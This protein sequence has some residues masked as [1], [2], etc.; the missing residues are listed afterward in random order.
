MSIT[1][2]FPFQ[3][4]F[5]VADDTCE[6]IQP[7]FKTYK[8]LAEATN[9]QFF[10]IKS[11]DT[12]AVV[13]DLSADLDDGASILDVIKA[14]PGNNSYPVLV[15]DTLKDFKV[16]LSGGSPSIVVTNPN[17]EVSKKAHEVLDLDNVKTVHVKNPEPG[18]WKIDT[19]S[20]TTH[21]V[22]VSGNSKVTFNFGFSL[23]SP[24]SLAETQKRP[25]HDYSN[26]LCLEPSNPLLL[27]SLDEVRFFSPTF[28]LR[29]PLQPVKSSSVFI[30]AFEPPR[31]IFKIEVF[32]RDASGNPF[33][34]LLPTGVNPI[35]VKKPEY[36][37][38]GL[39][40]FVKVDAGETVDLDCIMAGDPQPTI[41]WFKNGE[42]LPDTMETLLVEEAEK[43]EY[44]C[45]GENNGGS[46]NVTFHVNSANPPEVIDWLLK[47]KN[48]SSVMFDEE[49][50]NFL[51]CPVKGEPE[52]TIAWFRD[53]QP[54]VNSSLIVISE[55]SQNVRFHDI[56]KD[57]TGKYKCVAT[58]SQGSVSLHF[59]VELNDPPKFKNPEEEKKNFIEETEIY[60]QKVTPEKDKEV[61]LKCDVTGNPEPAIYW[62]KEI[63]PIEEVRELVQTNGTEL[64]LPSVE[65]NSVFLCI[66]NNTNGQLEKS[67]EIDVPSL[68]TLKQPTDQRVRVGANEVF[69]MNCDV[70][71]PTGVEIKWLK[72]GIEIPEGLRYKLFLD[73]LVLKIVN[74]TATEMGSY[75][76]VVSNSVGSVEKIFN[77]EM[78]TITKWADWSE[79]SVC[80]CDS[81][82]QFRS[83]Q[84]LY[85]NETLTENPEGKCEGD[86]TEMRPCSEGC[87]NVTWSDWEPWTPCNVTCGKGLK[88]R[89]RSCLSSDASKC[90][91]EA[92]ESESCEM[93]P[94]DETTTPPVTDCEKGFVFSEAQGSCQ[95]VDECENGENKCKYSQLCVNTN[96]TY[97][98]ICPEGF[99]Q[100][101]FGNKCLDINE[102]SKKVHECSHECVNTRG[103]Y[104]CSC[105]DGMKLGEDR[106][107]CK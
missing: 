79:W 90:V 95:D 3:L 5:I 54:L 70:E 100:K 1:R 38:A 103:S 60:S 45:V 67:F 16:T 40:Q 88:T 47:H 66:A 57:V 75:K 48:D 8:D 62:F 71:D 44:M 26:Y 99:V 31:T 36:L 24:T 13:K 92:K 30:C 7:K 37:G 85:M 69:T 80:N 84:C 20:N 56:E 23:H 83:R 73:G 53:E 41:T 91:G 15:D 98:C 34:R 46:V 29:V 104:K 18:E 96:G 89:T 14:S 93:K 33:K 68:P 6:E 82:V 55:N 11:S 81:L 49:S 76:C 52:P 94:C 65:M 50:T 32:G 64:R 35:R 102:C 10:N 21:K 77:V 86:R 4:N 27:V 51:N 74:A 43:A 2:N 9:G 63:D 28:N 78:I 42:K 22:K 72:D 105:P 61:T 101:G 25:L 58:N 17:N 97:N 39:D 12:S 87:S 59:T 107:N 19:G 106:K